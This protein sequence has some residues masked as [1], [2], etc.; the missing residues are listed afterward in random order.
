VLASLGRQLRRPLQVESLGA[1]LLVAV[2]HLGG[3]TVEM[4]SSHGSQNVAGDA[5]AVVGTIT[6]LV[7]AAVLVSLWVRFARGPASSER[8]VRYAAAALVAF[9]ALGKVLSPQFLIW[10]FP[11]VAL[12]A[13]RRGLAA[14]ALLGAALVTTQAWFPDRYWDYALTFEPGV[15]W[16]VL[17][18]DL[19]LVACLV[20]LVRRASSRR[21]RAP[22]RR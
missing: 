2:D 5:A 4:E 1:A 13:G 6:T 19:L 18:R 8:L 20:V 9:V 11:V 12:V 15:S 16:L 21:A 14:S 10:L 3:P 7:Q 22:A 17:L